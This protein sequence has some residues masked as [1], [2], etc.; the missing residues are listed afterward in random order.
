MAAE[1]GEVTFW[2]KGRCFVVEAPYSAEWI[3][4]AKRRFGRWDSL[5]GHRGWFFERRL[6]DHRVRQMTEA[7]KQIFGTSPRI[8]D[9]DAVA[10]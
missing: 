4:E 3:A 2:L 7:A 8:V 9:L 5:R 1:Q 10:A 6:D